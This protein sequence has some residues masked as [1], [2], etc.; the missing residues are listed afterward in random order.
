MFEKVIKK[1]FYHVIT[2]KP[3]MI[4]Q[5][6]IYDEM[7]HSGVYERVYAYKD[8]VNEI[9]AKPEAYK[10]ESFEHHLKVALRELAMEEVRIN[11][12]PNYPSRLS[13]LYVSQTLEEAEKW[14]NLFIELG[15]HTFQIVKVE[16]TG[17][18]FIGD[19]CNCFD[20][21]NDKK[22]NLKLAENYW[23]YKT[24]K[25]KKIPI[26]EVLVDGNIKVIDIIKENN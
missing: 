11:K 23:K 25:N 17:N 16:V 2:N 7:H 10:N 24:N 14:Y 12:Y 13:S 20:G 1:Q 15:R 18:V 26:I 5:Q 8:I 21:T 22:R 9:Y 4:G 3:M 6:I 19:A